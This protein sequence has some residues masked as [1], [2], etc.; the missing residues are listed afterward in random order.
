M[1]SGELLPLAPERTVAGQTN[2]GPIGSSLLLV[3]TR[4]HDFA[5]SEEVIGM[6]RLDER[7]LQ[8]LAID[9]DDSCSTMPFQQD[10]HQNHL[11]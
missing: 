7:D 8:V 2:E 4:T 5:A 3:V 10:N 6:Q 1:R 9:G 11:T